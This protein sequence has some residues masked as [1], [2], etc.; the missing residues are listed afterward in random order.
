MALA[1][2]WHLRS[3]SKE[4]AA[5]QHPFINGEKFITAIFP[6]LQNGGYLRQDFT[7]QGWAQRAV[8]AATP[9]SFWKNT[10]VE[11]LAENRV[12]IYKEDAEEILR[13]LIEKDESHT[14]NVRFILAVMLERQKLLRE[15]DAQRTGDGIIRVYEHRKTGEIFIVKDPNLPLDQVEAVQTEVMEL[16]G[17]PTTAAKE[18]FIS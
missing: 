13:G 10:F 3:R 18:I 15:T 2:N 17:S 16:L 9:F 6:D 7:L 12:E 1:E 5:T 4:C 8:S 14:E 11:H